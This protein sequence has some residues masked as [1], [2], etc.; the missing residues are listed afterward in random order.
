[1]PTEKVASIIESN[2]QQTNCVSKHTTPCISFA[3]NIQQQQQQK[4]GFSLFLI[5][6]LRLN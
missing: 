2:I 5:G 6:T 4:P 1:M 3:Y